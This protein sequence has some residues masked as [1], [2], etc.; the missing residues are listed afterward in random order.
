[1]NQLV[2]VAVTKPIR[3]M[4]SV[5][6]TTATRRPRT[7]TGYW[8]PYPTVVTVAAA[9]HRASPKLRTVPPSAPR[10]ASYMARPHR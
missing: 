10:S 4:P 7:V 1:M 5:I 6:S 8:S 2:V 3:L 9:H